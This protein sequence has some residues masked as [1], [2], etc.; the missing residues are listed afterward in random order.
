MRR[1]LFQFKKKKTK[2]KQ[3]GS[4]VGVLNEYTVNGKLEIQTQVHLILKLLAFPL[5]Y[6]IILAPILSSYVGT[7]D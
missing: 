7:E 5:R 2:T 4:Q 3:T 1:L 6:T